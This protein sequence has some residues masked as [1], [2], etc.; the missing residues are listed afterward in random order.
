MRN[1]KVLLAIILVVL[2]LAPTPGD[3]GGCGQ[4]P[5]ILDARAFFTNKK[6]IDCSR[7]KEC[8]LISHTC[9]DACD[10]N[11]A[12]KSSF[13]TDC[14][15]LVHDGEVCLHALEY[16]SCGD[17]EGYVADSSPASPSEC[18]FCPPR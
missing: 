10:D 1:A 9:D 3:I 16:A 12:V 7:C 5:D 14:V 11:A 13:P 18:N 4:A 15:P 2:C 8:G 6:R 17:Y